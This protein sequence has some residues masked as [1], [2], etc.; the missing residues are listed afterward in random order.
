[1]KALSAPTGFPGCI[2]EVP[3]KSGGDGRK[4]EKRAKKGKGGR[5]GKGVRLERSGGR[6]WKEDKR[7]NRQFRLRLL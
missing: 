3:K 5:G 7:T 2:G 6:R 4:G 1:L